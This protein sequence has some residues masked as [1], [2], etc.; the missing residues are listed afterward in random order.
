LP[1]NEP[2]PPSGEIIRP[3][4]VKYRAAEIWDANVATL[5]A[6]VTL[7]VADVQPFA[8]WCVGM[9]E[10]EKKEWDMKATDKAELR[11]LESILGIGAPSRT[12]LGTVKG[13]FDPSRK[14]F[15][16]NKNAG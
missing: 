2:V 13:K 3:A 4:Y 11:H 1:E 16:R 9:A 8:R 14:Y 7:T 6:M 10:F 5:T 15:D 12:K